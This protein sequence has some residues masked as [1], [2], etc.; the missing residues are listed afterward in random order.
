LCSELKRSKFLPN[1]SPGFGPG[2]GRSPGPEDN[3][4]GIYGKIGRFVV[5]HFLP[6]AYCPI[7]DI[8]YADGIPISSLWRIR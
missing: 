3:S 6:T 2:Y 5:H 7:R 1:S 4:L 8:E